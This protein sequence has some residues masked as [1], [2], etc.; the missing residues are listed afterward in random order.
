MDSLIRSFPFLWFRVYENALFELNGGPIMNPD[1]SYEQCVMLRDWTLWAM[2]SNVEGGRLPN[3][4]RYL[5]E[6]NCPV[7]AS[8]LAV[9]SSWTIEVSLISEIGISVF[10]NL[11]ISELQK[12]KI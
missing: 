3:I 9:L 6:L 8:I 1:W 2:S 5:R 4:A 12:L 10:R 11:R 7:S